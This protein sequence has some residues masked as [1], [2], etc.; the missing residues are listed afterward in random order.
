M[1]LGTYCARDKRIWSHD[2]K[3]VNGSKYST[4]L[5]NKTFF[6]GGG[7]RQGFSV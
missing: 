1:Y 5:E 2:I 7:L 6:M 4:V 3:Y